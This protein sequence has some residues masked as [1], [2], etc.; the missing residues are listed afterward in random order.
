V[1]C[2]RGQASVC[3]LCVVG[4]TQWLRDNA[5]AL[6][7]QDAQLKA[8][9]DI[10]ERESR[11][12]SAANEILAKT[13]GGLQQ[14]VAHINADIASVKQQVAKLTYHKHSLQHLDLH[15]QKC[16]T[17][18]FLA[19]VKKTLFPVLFRQ[20]LVTKYMLSFFL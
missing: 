1:D 13:V 8:S 16:N 17:V 20:P 6:K 4:G 11:H 12:L 9:N 3:L 7:K 5:E 15:G 18:V 19:V 2:P 14:R 10:F